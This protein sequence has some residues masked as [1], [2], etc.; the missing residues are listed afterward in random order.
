MQKSELER[1]GSTRNF[2]LCEVRNLYSFHKEKF[3]VSNLISLSYSFNIVHIQ[4]NLLNNVFNTLLGF[5]TFVN[6]VSY[7]TE[8]RNNSEYPK[9]DLPA[10]YL[11]Y[12]GR[13]KIQDTKNTSFELNLPV[14]NVI[15]DWIDKQK[16]QLVL[17]KDGKWKLY[18]FLG[19][20]LL[21]QLKHN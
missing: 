12:F 13:C 20:F 14:K 5:I 6:F 19:K 16:L 8:S 11:I 4:T 18:L 1:V 7:W 10:L 3:Q 9:L 17:D 2:Q 21:G 15:L